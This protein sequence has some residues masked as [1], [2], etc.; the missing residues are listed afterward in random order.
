[1]AARLRIGTFK[2]RLLGCCLWLV[3]SLGGAQ[4]LVLEDDR[5]S[6]I[7]AELATTRSALERHA[8]RRAALAQTLAE[9]P[10]TERELERAL[11]RDVR[12]LYRLH[13]GGLL[14]LAGG[15]EA[16]VTHASRVAHLER[17]VELTQQKLT[18]TRRQGASLASEV[19][20]LETTLRAA[21]QQ[22]QALE[23]AR[24]ERETKAAA[25]AALAA[26]LAASAEQESRVEGR[27]SYGLTVVGGT[28]RETFKSQRGRLALPVSAAATIHDAADSTG[29]GKALTFETRAGSSVRAA[30]AGRVSSVEQSASG[31]KVVLDHGGRYRTVYDQL[32]SSDVEP[33]DSVSKSA[34]V[35]SAGAAPVYFEVKRGSRSQDARSFL[36]L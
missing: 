21:E 1:M 15:L 11:A 5:G 3:T 17:M 30:A 35:G 22:A 31:V 4:D 32:A 6:S 36:G 16:L 7:D 26:Q 10:H 29:Q 33:G 27:G 18:A 12:A 13:R 24:Q 20:E 9:L 14:P 19:A 34:R 23:Q 28:E 25:E 2:G 8:S